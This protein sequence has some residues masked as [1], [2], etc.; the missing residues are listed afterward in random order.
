[1]GTP[2][3]QLVVD[4]G[5]SGTKAACFA[6]DELMLP[7]FRFPAGDWESIDA[8]VTNL[9]VN[10]IIYST[11][12]NVPSERWIDKWKRSGIGVYTLDRKLPLPFS[13]AYRT[14]ETLGQDRIA[15]VAGTL[16][17]IDTSRLIVDAGSCVTLD[18]V[19]ARDHYLGGNISPGVAMR[20]RSMH[21]FTARLPLVEPGQPRGLVGDATREALLHGGQLGV[22]YEIEGL[23]G[24]LLSD[25]RDLQVVLT[26]GDA[27]HLLPYFSIK[28]L[29]Y[30]NLVLRGLNQILST[31]VNTFS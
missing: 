28:I 12:A 11:V 13:S 24:R 14:M 21:A 17:R 5:N 18:L 26:G 20:M 22:V 15:A 7:V 19:N 6:D 25:H 31:Y 1:M 27:P 29:S 4:V 16:G 10:N 3:R 8:R 23:Y 9:G 30:P 2:H